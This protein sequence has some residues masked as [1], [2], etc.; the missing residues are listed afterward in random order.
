MSHGSPTQY[1]SNFRISAVKSPRRKIDITAV[2]VP[3]VTCDL[4]VHP[5]PF[6]SKW[7]HLISLSL[8]DPTFGRPGR[9]N[10]LLGVNVFA[11]VLRQGRRT[12]PAGSPV[13][14]VTEFGWVLSGQAEP[15][16]STEH[17]TTHHTSVAF[18]DDTLC[19]FWEI[20]EAPTSEVALLLEERG[21]LNHFK[22]NYSRAEGGRFVVPLPKRPDAKLIGESRSQAV[23]RFLSLECSLNSRGRFQ[24]FE[25]VMRE[26]VDLGH[27]ELVPSKD[28]EK[29][30]S[31]VFYLPMHAVYKSL[32]TTTK[33]RAVFDASA[34][35]ASG[36]SLNDILLVGPTVH[37]PAYRCPLTLLASSDCCY[38]RRQQNVPGG[39]TVPF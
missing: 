2:I 27:A 25:P 12:G 4:P 33:I 31:Q 5:V 23:R 34:K 20:E 28:M 24:E 11:D 36:V 1:I 14:F 19:R 3:K 37:P 32:S 9:I 30:E 16:S 8:A 38:S 22:A 26:Y 10:I 18:K 29:P 21:V 13:V 6:D 39:G 15:S 7:K 35:S 17:V